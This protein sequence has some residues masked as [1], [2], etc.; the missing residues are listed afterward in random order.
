MTSAQNAGREDSMKEAVELGVKMKREWVATLD[1][2]TRHTHRDLHGVRVDVNEPWVTEY[3][4][5]I[6][7]PGDP[8]AD[9]GEVY[10]CRCTMRSVVEGFEG[11]TV[12][13]SP[14]MGEMSYKDWKEGGR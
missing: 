5:E 13:S 14:K 8:S 7:Y 3:G 6:M 2:R 11:N 4:D 1:D 12:T 9:A 10:N